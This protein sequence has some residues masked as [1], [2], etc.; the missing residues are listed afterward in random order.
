M[1]C[2]PLP[3]AKLVQDW[4]ERHRNPVSLVLHLLG[5]PISVLGLLMVPV[6]L[7]LFSGRMFL[8]SAA[9]FLGGYAL[10]FLGHLVEWTEPGEITGI[11]R[12]L[13]GARPRPRS[14]DPAATAGPAA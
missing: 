13:S 8:F 11:R 1:I 3:P 14:A 12:A 5:I 9:L 4:V 10:Q 2:P 6:Y 7:A